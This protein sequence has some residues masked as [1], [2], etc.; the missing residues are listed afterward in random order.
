MTNPQYM[1]R[2]QGDDPSVT[3]T[4]LIDAYEDG[5][6]ALRL[7]VATMTDDEARARP[8]P[9]KWS[10]LEVVAHIAGA[11]I[12]FSER[13]ER[14]I[15]LP[16]PLLVGVDETPYPARLGYQTLDLHEELNLVLALRGHTARILRQ[17][18]EEA[19]NRTAIHTETGLVTLRQ[20][21][22]H[23][24]RHIPHHLRFIEEKKKALAE[25]A[26][27]PT[28]DLAHRVMVRPAT[29]SDVPGITA[30]YNEAIT[31]TTAT[32]DLEPKTVEN[33]LEWFRSHGPRHPILVADLDGKVTGWGS[34]S[35]WSDRCAY[36]DTGESSFYVAPEYR[37]MGIGRMLKKAVL[38][39]ARRLKYHT[40]MA[41]IAGESAASIHLNE[42][43]G[44]VK[45]GTLKEVGRKFGRLI[46]VHMYQLLV[47]G[48]V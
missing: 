47:N 37:G 25:R 23:A 4:A 16:N 44:F 8:I 29:E 27:K 43:F 39:E 24:V 40:I 38:D 19:W 12:Y 22:W 17:Q 11:E 7:A 15:A 9:G 28:G 41:R 34:I 18:G 36:S 42:E 46:D 10:T 6:R 45:V 21:L 32:F 13:I 26:A 1:F 48:N 5:A 31:N 14:T 20:I 33:R 35:E 30:I 3:H 2:M